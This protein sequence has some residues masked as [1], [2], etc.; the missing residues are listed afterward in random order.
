MADGNSSNG[1]PKLVTL[2]IDDREVTVPEGTRLIDAALVQGADVPHYCYH[3]GL[4]V[5]GN[6][7][8]CIVEIVGGRGNPLQ[9]ACNTPVAE[10][11]VV[12]TESEAV[13]KRRADVLEFLL[14]NH[15]LDC[16]ICDQAGE[17]LLQIYYMEHDRQK[18]RVEVDKVHK[19]KVVPIGPRVMLDQERCI[20]CTRCVRF[21]DEVPKTGELCVVNRGDH[22]QLTTFPGKQVDNDYSENI[23]DICPVG[24]LTSRLFR[25]QAR[26]WF[27]KGV[28]TVC[29]RCATGCN[30]R[31]DYYHHEVVDFHNGKAYRLVPRYNPQVNGHWMCDDGRLAFHDVNDDRAHTPQRRPS[32]SDDQVPV[33]YREALESARAWVQGARSKGTLAGIAS[34]ECTLEELH[35]FRKLFRHAATS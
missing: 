19:D 4:S 3:P 27:L 21:L 2:T 33:S 20:L 9:I 25:F 28:D 17:C 5:A 34:P 6:C 7:R 35:L 8:I 29:T 14:V 11:M 1:E 12:K 15:P 18:S 26:A 22:S 13:L 31:V 24:A 10:G 23:V 32:R 30:V 16:P